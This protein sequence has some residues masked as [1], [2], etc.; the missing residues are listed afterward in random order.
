M[1]TKIMKM[2]KR[3]N[4]IKSRNQFAGLPLPCSRVEF[5]LISPMSI[6]TI[7]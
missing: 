2:I 6:R 5:L 1:K 4:T 3:K 7:L